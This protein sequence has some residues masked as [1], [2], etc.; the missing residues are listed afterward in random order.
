SI[1]YLWITDSGNVDLGQFHIGYITLL[2]F[3]SLVKMHAILAGYY[4]KYINI[5]VRLKFLSM[6]RM[7]HSTMKLI[8]SMSS[9]IFVPFICLFKENAEVVEICYNV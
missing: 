6:D 2:L 4:M 1:S 7:N 8:P 9:Y 5:L 3:D